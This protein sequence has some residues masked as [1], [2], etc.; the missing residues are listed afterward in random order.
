MASSRREP[1]P[2]FLVFCEQTSSV[3]PEALSCSSPVMPR[4]L[5]SEAIGLRAVSM[6]RSWVFGHPY[7]GGMTVG[8]AMKKNERS[9]IERKVN[10]AFQIRSILCR[11]GR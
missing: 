6:T 4:S 11:V 7:T 2:M 9:C 5:R 1:W 8:S 10:N 3:V